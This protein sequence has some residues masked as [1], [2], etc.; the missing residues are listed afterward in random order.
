MRLAAISLL[1]WKAYRRTRIDI[2]R[3]SEGKNVVVIE[4]N[5][6][7]GKT[8][9]LEAVTFCLFGRFGLASVARA[10]GNDKPDQSYSGFLERALNSS[11]RG[12]A[13]RITVGLEFEDG[14]SVIG[15]ERT[16]HFSASGRHKA[17]DE[18]IR[19]FDGPDMDIVMLP[20]PAEAEDFVRDFVARRLLSENLAGFFLLDGEHI[21]RLAGHSVDSQ[22]WGAIDAVLGAPALRTLASDLRAYARE[23]RRQLPQHLTQKSEKIGEELHN[24]E[25]EERVIGGK[26]E[27]LLADLMPLRD[28]R[29][30]IVKTIGSL[31]GDSYRN[32]KTLF[33]DRER[34]SRIRDEKRDELRRVFI[35][36]V[37]LALAGSSLRERAIERLNAED[38]T[39]RWETSSLVSK[40]RFNEFTAA[41]SIRGDC[42]IPHEILRV[43][44]DD[45]WS[46]RPADCVTEI[47]HTHLGDADRTAVREHL[48]LLS[49]VRA[50]TISELSKG[51]RS[52]DEQI[53]KC[54]SDIGRQRGLD[55]ESQKLA[56]ALTSVQAE[57]AEAEASH[58]SAL[59]KHHEIV[60]QLTALRNEADVLL[61][62]G[63]N[64]APVVARAALA[65]RFADLADRV[66]D[67]ALPANLD[68][69]AETLTR[70]Y[71]EMAH[72]S[73][74]E[75]VRIE[76]NKPVQLLDG[77]GEDIRSVDASA[78]ESQVF[79]LA[80]MSALSQMAADFPILMDTPLARLDP[81]HRRNVLN[82][83]SSGT[84]QL[85]LL[86][87]PAELGPNEMEILQPK[88]AGVIRIGNVPS[89]ALSEVQA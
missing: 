21:E 87:H 75:S 63:V 14:E 66:V 61:A 18:E 47:R 54:E 56:N 25:L 64:A 59:Q 65:E 22:I 88:L 32:F 13:N 83:F 10:K 41:L 43:A 7:A 60:V 36:D 26:V 80:V 57:I 48:Q 73:V 12:K 34:L 70:S 77:N 20:P 2:P 40:G 52:L 55:G 27:R 39:A 89:P 33:E 50:G 81:L 76:A 9:L 35:G 28:K 3:P 19:L 79:A 53:A 16:W 78:G 4:G 69:I 5:N 29:D 8:S 74:V 6:G 37:A 42:S 72:K 15:I 1:N 68:R 31:H 82:H 58:R 24:A 71:R 38:R 86:T 84:R 30:K 44:W 11:A 17:D 67:G 45:V 49:S 85:I 23:R 46:S 51:I 62:D